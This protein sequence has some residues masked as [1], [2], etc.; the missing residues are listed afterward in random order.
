MGAVGL[1][2]GM[3]A[4]KPR[5]FRVLLPEDGRSG[6]ERRAKLYPEARTGVP[7]EIKRT[8]AAL[9]GMLRGDTVKIPLETAA[10]ETCSPFRQTVYRAAYRIPRGSVFTYG[11]LAERIGRGGAAR[12]VGNALAANPFPLI[13]PCHRVIR[14]DGRIGGFT[15]GAGLKRRL[16]EAEGIV[17]NR[18]GRASPRRLDDYKPP[19]NP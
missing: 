13:V 8:A 12:A 10:L 16:L 19:G 3:A 11:E 4:G 15:G 5:V 17:F 1:V 6:A 18:S 14:S 2:W 7:A 9:A